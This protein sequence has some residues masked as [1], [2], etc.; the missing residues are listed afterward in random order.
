VDS[1]QN[2]GCSP[3]WPIP[4]SR[5]TH[6]WPQ[7]LGSRSISLWCRSLRPFDGRGESCGIGHEERTSPRQER[8]WKSRRLRPNGGIVFGRRSRSCE[9]SFDRD[10]R[11][12]ATKPAPVRPP[13]VPRDHE[14]PRS[15]HR[16]SGVRSLPVL[17]GRVRVQPAQQYLSVGLILHDCPSWC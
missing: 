3:V 8:I 6:W 5:S 7:H 1:P 2:F 13:V 12:L 14:Q 4:C 11:A 17:R 16:P 10:L 15:E 9:S